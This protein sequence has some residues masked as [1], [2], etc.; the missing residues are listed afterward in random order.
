MKNK[1]QMCSP[2]G[3]VIAVHSTAH[4]MVYRLNNNSIFYISLVSV[5]LLL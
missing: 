3:K 4:A 1:R 2:C 5:M